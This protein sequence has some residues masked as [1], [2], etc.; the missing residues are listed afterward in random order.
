MNKI[1]SRTGVKWDGVQHA[2][3]YTDP[4]QYKMAVAERQQAD[5]IVE[6]AEAEALETMKAMLKSVLTNGNRVRS[7]F[8]KTKT[9]AEIYD[10]IDNAQDILDLESAVRKDFFT[11]ERINFLVYRKAVDNGFDIRTYSYDMLSIFSNL[12]KDKADK[13]LSDAGLPYKYDYEKRELELTENSDFEI[14][15][16]SSEK[17]EKDELSKNGER[18][19]LELDAFKNKTHKGLLHLGKPLG[20]LKASGINAEEMT[21]SPSVLYGHLKKHSLTTDDLKGLAQSIQSPILVYK[22]GEHSPNIVV[23]TELDVKGGKLSASFELDNNGNIVK[24]SNISSIHSKEA[25]KELLRLFKMGEK[26]FGKALRWVEKEK[27]LD[28]LAPSS[29][30]PSG[31]QA[32]EAPFDIANV[33]RSFENPKVSDENVANDGIKLS[34]GDG[35]GKRE[36]K[37]DEL[38]SELKKRSENG[39]ENKSREELEETFRILC[40]L[41]A[42]AFKGYRRLSDTKLEH[43]GKVY[44]IKHKM[45][46]PLADALYKKGADVAYDGYALYLRNKDGVQMSLHTHIPGRSDN[47]FE[48]VP[49]H[50]RDVK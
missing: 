41:N 45:M 36:G 39:F 42:L 25:N 31:M 22:H 24:V 46:K 18:F 29:Y 1:L 28:W 40:Q 30:E 5:S 21:I 33:I 17:N 10:G 4:R 38:I 9:R 7:L 16:S 19:N 13:K 37:A 47:D 32:E 6:D 49:Y 44:S 23:V 34:L 20:I 12:V 26:D 2:Y 35:V 48:D 11:A 8:G 50:N 15:E 3:K 14:S 43:N 27:V